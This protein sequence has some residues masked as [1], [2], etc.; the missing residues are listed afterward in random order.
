LIKKT[1][2]RIKRAE[3]GECPIS[4]KFKGGGKGFGRLKC[5]GKASGVLDQGLD[6]DDEKRSFSRGGK[7]VTGQHK[8]RRMGGGKTS[9]K[10]KMPFFSL[11]KKRDNL[12]SGEGN[13]SWEK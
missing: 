9:C 7:K 6:F 13:L 1:G 11:T 8:R 12:H 10:R 3:R 2:P 4:A 5:P